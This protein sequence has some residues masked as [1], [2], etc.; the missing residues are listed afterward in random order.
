[1]RKS[2]LNLIT[3]CLVLGVSSIS[4]SEVRYTPFI[5][6]YVKHSGL[7]DRHIQPDYSVSECVDFLNQNGIKINWI[8]V[9]QNRSF[10]EKSMARITGQT[11]LLLSG[12]GKS[13]AAYTLPSEFETWY[14]FCEIYGLEYKK[15]YKKL[16]TIFN[17]L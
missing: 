5:S 9:Y 10:D 4:V 8:D 12:A 11:F 16:L 14:Q 2:S 1:M 6:F 13:G 17:N 7:F 15:S 3:I